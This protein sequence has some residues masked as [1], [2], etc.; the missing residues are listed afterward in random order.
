MSVSPRILS[1]VSS[2]T[3]RDAVL[4][5]LR[6][7]ILTGRLA[8]GD[9]LKEVA[10]AKELAVSRPTLR[11]AIYQLIHEGL[12]IQ[13]NYKGI[14]VAGI[15]PETI[16]DVAV[17]RAALETIAAKAIAND[18]SGRSQEALRSAWT[19]Y[20]AAAQSGDTVRENEAHLELHRTIW[21]ASGN[22]MLHRIWPIVS[23]SIHL[24]LTADIAMRGDPRR[25]RRKHLELV[26][27]ILHGRKRE[28]AG[29][30]RDHINGSADELLDMLH[31][32]D[33]PP[34]SNDRR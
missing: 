7:A 29:T 4:S 28:I 25:N 21:L 13:E 27:A 2:V 6:S 11:E 15:D 33:V 17:V 24:V 32:R 12:L 30:M 22:T 3:R 20:D 5:E 26:D 8:P 10:L 23:A 16:A 31:R 34:V 18:K 19:T 14:T 1:P 9:R